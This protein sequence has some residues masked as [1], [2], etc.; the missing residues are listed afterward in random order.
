MRLLMK[1]TQMFNHIR[2]E[3][4]ISYL[5]TLLLTKISIIIP[6][7]SKINLIAKNKIRKLISWSQK[8]LAIRNSQILQNSLKSMLAMHST[9]HIRKWWSSCIT[10]SIFPPLRINI[11]WIN[12]KIAVKNGKNFKNADSKEWRIQLLKWGKC[13]SMRI[14][15]SE[16]QLQNSKILR[17]IHDYLKLLISIFSQNKKRNDIIFK[18]NPLLINYTYL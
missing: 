17:L 16:M 6:M 7:R 10:F 9:T 8:S 18:L 4:S 1:S 5:K 2:V 11:C 3:S 13:H 15:S 14:M 12:L